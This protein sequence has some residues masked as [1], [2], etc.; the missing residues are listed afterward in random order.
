ML[1]VLSRAA[2]FGVG[3]DARGQA[4]VEFA[5]PRVLMGNNV[6]GAADVPLSFCGSTGFRTPFNNHV[7]RRNADDRNQ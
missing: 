7:E 1:G 4:T 2:V 5:S 6:R 3:D